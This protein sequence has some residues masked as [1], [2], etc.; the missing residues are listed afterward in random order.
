MGARLFGGNLMKFHHLTR[1][2]SALYFLILT[3]NATFADAQP[4]RRVTLRGV[5]NS[6]SETTSFDDVVLA[7]PC[8]SALAEEEIE[9]RAQLITD[10]QVLDLEGITR[11]LKVAFY[12]S[13]ERA[14]GALIFVDTSDIE[15]ADESEKPLGFGFSF[16]RS[17]VA[18][19]GVK[20]NAPKRGGKNATFRFEWREGGPIQNITFNLDGIKVRDRNSITNFIFAR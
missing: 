1:L 18:Y 19:L 8:V 13:G 10:V 5:L 14:Y 7:G 3:A 16:T 6:N 4:T 20:G 17:G 15:C 12:R 11:T 2:F 9:S